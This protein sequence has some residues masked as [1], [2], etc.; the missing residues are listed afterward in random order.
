MVSTDGPSVRPTAK[1]VKQERLRRRKEARSD[2]R[3]QR[4]KIDRTL[5]EFQPDAVEIEERSVAGGARYTLYTIIGLII[6]T[7]VW[8]SWAEVDQYVTA[9][10][11]LRTVEDPIRIQTVS[12]APVKTINV[13]FGDHVTVGQVIASLDATFSESDLRQLD[14]RIQSTDATL[15]RLTAEQDETE[16]SVDG[17]EDKSD[18]HLE[19]QVY[20]E[21][22]KEYDAKIKEFASEND[23]LGVQR[24]NNLSEATQ[25]V[26]RI[27]ALKKLEQQYRDLAE[28]GSKSPVDV[29]TR[30]LQTAESEGN[31]EKLRSRGRELNMEV[32]SLEKRKAAFIASW[33]SQLAT[34]LIDASKE[35][36]GLVE[37]LAKAKRSNELAQIVVPKHDEYTDF[38][39]LEVAENTIGSVVQPG[40]HLFKLVPISAPLEVECQI[41]GRD[42]AR[43]RAGDE[44]RIKIN[45]FPFQKHGTLDGNI[46][47]I[48]YG[49]FESKGAEANPLIPGTNYKARI[50]IETPI[51]LDNVPDDFELVPGM[52]VQSEIKVG[53]R[54]V[55][56][57]FL[58]PIIRGLDSSLR[59]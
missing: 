25:L 3:A 58:Y 21:R 57:Y 16:F 45:T 53:R 7:V 34:A 40:E 35:R 15:A 6:S 1:E 37:E 20:L 30:E 2:T 49:A 8:A 36:N 13:K 12:T 4:Q 9:T 24:E 47:T 5:V 38:V 56:S 33:R 48:S 43:V 42:I 41:P 50:A 22:A 19:Y 27:A 52:T 32:D 14:T 44:V 29:L 59:E 55:I 28:R 46:R 54:K 11:K 51:E 10:G 39:V 18:W 17:H 23:K 31:L 26:K